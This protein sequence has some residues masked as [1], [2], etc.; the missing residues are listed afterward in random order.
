MLVGVGVGVA[1]KK[2][3]AP[4]PETPVMDTIM[5]STRPLVLAD[6]LEHKALVADVQLAVEH[7]A[8]TSDTVGVGSS[9]VVKARP[10]IEIDAEPEMGQFEGC[11]ADSTGAAAQ[12]LGSRGSAIARSS[13][14]DAKCAAASPSKVNSPL[15]EPTTMPTVTAMRADPLR[16]GLRQDTE[17]VEDQVLVVHILLEVMTAVRVDS[18]EPKLSPLSVSDRPPLCGP[19]TPSVPLTTGAAHDAMAR[20]IGM[21]AKGLIAI[22][23]IEAHDC[24]DTSDD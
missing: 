3:D 6:A 9:L 23:T 16:E 12:T 14:A 8:T 18:V 24:A 19:L 17:V 21:T 7:A 1:S 22:R 13:Q 15:L 10:V 2:I 20:D 5:P 11:T 4:V